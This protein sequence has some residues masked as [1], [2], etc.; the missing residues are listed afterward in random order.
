[1][2][3][4]RRGRIEESEGKFV[5]NVIRRSPESDTRGKKEKF[6][7]KKAGFVWRQREEGG[8]FM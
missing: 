8:A 6:R 7:K 5:F 4:E 2:T 3:V 1:M